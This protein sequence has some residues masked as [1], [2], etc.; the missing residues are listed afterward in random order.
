MTGPNPNL[1]HPIAM[2]PRVGFLKGLVNA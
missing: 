1:K 2:H